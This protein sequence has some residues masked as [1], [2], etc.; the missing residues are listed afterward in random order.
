MCR[1]YGFR[2]IQNVIRMVKRGACKY[3][4]VELLACPGGCSNGGGQIKSL[5]N[6]NGK[7][8]LQDVN[9]TYNDSSIAII[10]PLLNPFVSG[11]YLK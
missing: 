9:N 10:D 5:P 2:N 11:I 6:Q 7:Q 8:L 1:A 4:F 3:D